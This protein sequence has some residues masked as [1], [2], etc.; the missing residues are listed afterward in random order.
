M[1]LAESDYLQAKS[2]LEKSTNLDVKK[3]LEILLQFKKA[4][5]RFLCLSLN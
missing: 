1:E 3:K 5:A 4:R 2:S